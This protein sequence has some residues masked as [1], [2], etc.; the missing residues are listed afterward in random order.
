MNFE[1]YDYIFKFLLIG[2][3]G[4]GKSSLLIRFADDIFNET[5][6]STIGVDFK[7]RTITVEGKVVKLQI[8]D[9]A[10]QERF[11]TLTT[12]YYRSAN[13]II[14]VYDVTE[15]KTYEN[16]EQWLKEVG[17]FAVEG[18]EKL[19]VGNKC[20]LVGQRQ[21]NYEV[22][23]SFAEKLQISFIETSAK[24]S[25]NVERVFHTLA[26]ELKEKLGTPE[27]K[28]GADDDGLGV[29]TLAPSSEVKCG[30]FSQCCSWN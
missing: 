12:A 19:L 11:R 8:W 26:A 30:Y 13:G 2:D 21:V 27:T 28:P 5:F 18:V 15:K 14:M 25:T 1:H 24:D 7:I 9:T 22:A 4:V 6:I 10:G 17:K 3:S 23:R 29:A 20:D 16:L